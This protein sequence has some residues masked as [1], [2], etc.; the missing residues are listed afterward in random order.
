MVTF[1]MSMEE[2]KEAGSPECW[3]LSSKLHI[4]ASQKATVLM[5]SAVRMSDLTEST[6][7]NPCFSHLTTDGMCR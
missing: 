2:E 5:Y 1:T 7:L 6:M 4:V 3:Y